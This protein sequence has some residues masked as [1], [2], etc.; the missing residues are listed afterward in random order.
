[1]IRLDINIGVFIAYMGTMMAAISE[2][3]GEGEAKEWCCEEF[4]LEW[5]HS[6]KGLRE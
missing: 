6:K 5:E 1:M 3:F 4:D 2:L